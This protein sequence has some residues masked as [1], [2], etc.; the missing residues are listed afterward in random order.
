ML[1]I[2]GIVVLWVNCITR[3]V[4]EKEGLT[5]FIDC[6]WMIIFANPQHGFNFWTK[7][8]MKHILFSFFVG[9][10]AIAFHTAFMYSI[11]TNECNITILKK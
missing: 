3:N 1:F 4:E 10:G 8:D 2:F 5:G 9:L 7:Y 6:I 11:M